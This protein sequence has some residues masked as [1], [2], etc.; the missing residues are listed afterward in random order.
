[1]DT[2]TQTKPLTPHEVADSQRLGVQTV[3]D[4]ITIGLLIPDG[5]ARKRRVKLKATRAGARWRI[6]PADLGAFLK[7]MTDAYA[8]D[9]APTVATT[10]TE[11]KRKK[12]LAD[13]KAAAAAMLG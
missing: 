9:D 6:A 10:E 5:R 4:W 8:P 3:Y 2:A 11:A 7:T 13:G 1:M 12:R